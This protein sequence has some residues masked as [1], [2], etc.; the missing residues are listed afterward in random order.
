MLSRGGV[1][2]APWAV[3]MKHP[4]PAEPFLRRCRER[5]DQEGGEQKANLLA[6]SENFAGLRFDDPNLFALFGG[7]PT[8]VLSPLFRGIVEDKQRET[9]RKDVAANIRAR[10]FEPL[11]D[12]ARARLQMIE[13]D[14]LLEELLMFAVSC[15]TREAFVQRLVELTNPKPEPVY[16][17][18]KGKS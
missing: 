3:L 18:R 2:M 11:D 1:G 14:D 5:I 16:S 8:M 9:R 10:K 12:D 6:I 15:P 17:R 4:N 7:S 13:D